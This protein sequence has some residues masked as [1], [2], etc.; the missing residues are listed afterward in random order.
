MN[1]FNYKLCWFALRALGWCV[2]GPIKLGVGVATALVLRP[3]LRADAIACG[4]CG[5]GIALLGLWQC[6]SC[7]FSFHG[8]YFSRCELCGILPPYVDCARC[9]AST[10]NPLIFGRLDPLKRRSRERA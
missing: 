9:G 2:W 3:I 6:G 4:S 8:Y 1:A 10:Q 7:G 5:A